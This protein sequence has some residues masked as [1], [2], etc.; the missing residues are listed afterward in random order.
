[1]FDFAKRLAM[2]GLVLAATTFSSGAQ[3]DCEWWMGGMS[4]RAPGLNTGMVTPSQP[5][6]TAP[7]LGTGRKPS[8]PQALN[9]GCDS[10]FSTTLLSMSDFNG[11]TGQLDT[12]TVYGTTLRSFPCINAECVAFP[13][14]LWEAQ[15]FY[16]A[17]NYPGAAA[18][19]ADLAANVAQKCAKASGSFAADTGFF[20]AMEA[21]RNALAG[22]YLKVGTLVVVRYGSGEVYTFTYTGMM[23]GGWPNLSDPRPSNSDESQ[24]C[25]VVG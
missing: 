20:K 3:A 22:S 12:V 8:A 2:A 10:A 4:Q 9:S 11:L 15:A 16:L 24:V 17:N 23:N 21:V 13:M 1:M 7:V 25:K 14:S 5:K 6:A 18:A 19:I